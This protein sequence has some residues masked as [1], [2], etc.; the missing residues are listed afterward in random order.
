MGNQ[1]SRMT[2]NE[3]HYII[4]LMN[5]NTLNLDAFEIG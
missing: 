2:V 5:E 1:Y 3:C 4:E